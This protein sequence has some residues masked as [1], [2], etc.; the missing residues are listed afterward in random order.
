MSTKRA[1]VDP[2]KSF[3]REI[4]STLTEEVRLHCLGGFVIT[5][6]HEFDRVTVDVD[7]LPVASKSDLESLIN[8]AGQGSKLHKKYKVYLQIVGVAPVPIN[9]E[10]RLTE[11]FAGT[12][13]RLRLFALDPYDLVLSKLER[14]APRDREDFLYLAQKVP[15]DMDVLSG[16]YQGGT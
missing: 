13:K 7:I 8:L 16:R 5:M 4:D 9:Y 1:I 3:F 14:N 6:V 15:L 12:F 10:D 2:W 11:M